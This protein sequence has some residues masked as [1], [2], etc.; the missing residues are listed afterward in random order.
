MQNHITKLFRYLILLICIV[1][2]ISCSS[3]GK[4]PPKAIKGV[5]DLREWSFE[6]LEDAKDNNITLDGEWEFYWN[7]FPGND[8]SLPEEEKEYTQ[9]PMQWDGYKKVSNTNN[10]EIKEEILGGKGFATYRLKVLTSRIDQL[11]FRL[12]SQGSAYTLYVNNQIIFKGGIVGTSEEDSKPRDSV[13]YTNFTP[14]EKDFYIVLCVSNFHHARGGFWSSITMG[15]PQSISHLK[16]YYLTIDIFVSGVLFIM[17]IYHFSLFYLRRDD[18]SNLYFGLFCS[19][20]F[21]RTIITGERYIYSYFPHISYSVRLAL[22]YLTMNLV[23]PFPLAFFFSLYPTWKNKKILNIINI[24]AIILVSINIFLPPSIFT[25]TR[26]ISHMI[27]VII[28]ICLSTLIY[29][30]YKRDRE[31]IKIFMFGIIILTVITINDILHNNNIIVTGNLTPVGL[32]IFIFFQSFLLSSRFSKA[33]EDVKILSSTL[34]LSNQE[35]ELNKERATKAYL[36]L[37]ASQKQLVQSDKMITLGTMVAGV[38]HEINTPLGAIKANSENILESLR[39]LIQKLNPTLSHITI[40]DLQNAIFV[41]ELSK[42]TGTAYSSREARTVRKKVISILEE[43]GQKNVDVLADYII[44][45]GL[46]EALERSENILSHTDIEKYLSIAG[47]LHG[48]R[49]KSSVIQSSAERV[50]KIVKSLKSFMHF[51][52][53]ETK[54]V[55]DLTEG[56]ETVLIILHNKIKYGIEVIK[57]YGEN[58]PHIYCYPDELNQ[59]W[60]NLIHN[61]IQAM[62]EKGT[63][64]I[65]I[66]KKSNLKEIPDID[67]RNPEYKGEYIAVSIQDS[68]SGISPEIRS[69]IFQAFFTTKPA[70]EGSGLGLHIIGKILEK[71][72]GAL[73]LESEPGKTRFTVLL[74]V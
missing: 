16:E 46:V 42:E 7:T 17:G 53:N 52:Q 34:K 57:N 73:Y 45:L 38:A 26:I 54:V 61:A 66:E 70:G 49:K 8:F 51:D 32:V 23:L 6:S 29:L 20:I 43:R 13:D 41:L 36:D 14:I 69:K 64:Q 58:V 19:I 22:D 30:E 59:I 65:D 28:I 10:K 40:G 37:E 72:E 11:S 44:D 71:H 63:L 24:L 21:I 15:N 1:N 25:K 62:D 56:M 31:G 39:G 27:L 67:K 5:L 3:Q 48:I 2:Y 55:S 9:I 35:L 18:K 47:D 4:V 60:T 33:F 12:P 68:G 74:P 50:S